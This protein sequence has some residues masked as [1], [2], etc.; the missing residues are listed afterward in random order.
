MSVSLHTSEKSSKNER[1]KSSYHMKELVGE[2]VEYVVNENML[3]RGV[4][5]KIADHFN[6][7]R[8]YQWSWIRDF[9]MDYTRGDTIYDI[10]C[11]TGRNIDPNVFY[12][13]HYE[14]ESDPFPTCVGVDNCFEFV[15][16]CQNKGLTAIQ[17]DM[18][19]IPL[20]DDS[21]DGILSIASFHHLANETRRIQAL[22]EMKRLIRRG[23]KILLSVWSI[24]QPEKTRRVFEDYG[25]T[26]VPWG[27]KDEQYDRYYYIFRIDEIRELFEKVGLIVVKHIW[28]C[29]NEV[30]TLTKE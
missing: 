29:G 16:M 23:G 15:E 6:D 24:Q 11:G 4:Y 9:M 13:G 2:G 26:I 1:R 3:V 5:S 28:D 21:A 20:E 17:S 25:D 12:R 14:K 10:G 22:K 19:N 27:K 18:S 7:T 8:Q 30:F